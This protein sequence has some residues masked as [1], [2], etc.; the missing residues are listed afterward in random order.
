[1]NIKKKLKRKLSLTQAMYL[2]NLKDKGVHTIEVTFSGGGKEGS[3]LSGVKVEERTYY[4]D[5]EEEIKITS[6][7]NS[8]SLRSKVDDLFYD[9]IEEHRLSNDQFLRLFGWNDGGYGT[10]NINLETNQYDLEIR[11]RTTD[12]C[13]W[14]NQPFI[15]DTTLH[16]EKAKL[17]N[18]NYK[19]KGMK[20]IILAEKVELN[21]TRY[22]QLKKLLKSTDEED[23]NIACESIKNM[24]ISSIAVTLLAKNLT[25]GKRS[26]FIKKFEKRIVLITGKEKDLS[27]EKVWYKF[28]ESP[29]ITDFDKE[30]ITL[31]LENLVESTLNR[32][33]YK[34]INKINLDLKW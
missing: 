6:L 23:F 14:D 9:M 4:N 20:E 25:Y 17:D 16:D 21:K 15:E 29:Y 27:W 22:K 2:M 26:A 28:A 5:A 34:F 10:L 8:R 33:D 24:D 3:R 31:E 7:D 30:L 1:M 13:A 32:L 18:K 11:Y 12:I 19:N